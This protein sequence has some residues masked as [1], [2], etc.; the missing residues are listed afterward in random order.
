VK[1]RFQSLIAYIFQTPYYKFSYYKFSELTKG[2]NWCTHPYRPLTLMNRTKL[3]IVG[4]NLQGR[5]C[6]QVAIRSVQL[7]KNASSGDRCINWSITTM[8]T[9]P[10]NNQ[11][12]SSS[13]NCVV[14][15]SKAASQGRN[16]STH[17]CVV[18]IWGRISAA[19]VSCISNRVGSR[20]INLQIKIP[21]KERITAQ[22]KDRIGDYP[23]DNSLIF[24]IQ[25]VFFFMS[26]VLHLLPTGN[27]SQF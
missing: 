19:I 2:E 8:F 9:N 3:H 20:S 13:F 14:T 17:D 16:W 25:L 12:K 18:A 11:T 15:S 23:S 24:L 27:C 26:Y 1:R 22:S 7:P 5:I 4:K 10:G 21:T 6:E